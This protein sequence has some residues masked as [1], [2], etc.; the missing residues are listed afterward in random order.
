MPINTTSVKM[1]SCENRTRAFLADTK[2]NTRWLPS[3]LKQSHTLLLIL[4]SFINMFFVMIGI[5]WAGYF[6]YIVVFRLAQIS[7]TH[8]RDKLLKMLSGNPVLSGCDADDKCVR[9]LLR[10][11]NTSPQNEIVR[12]AISAHA[13]IRQA[14]ELHSA[15]PVLC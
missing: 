5:I 4:D 2:L 3:D 6:G 8:L 1:F 7:S 13:L 9:I 10:S 12:A 11:E 15:F 14:D